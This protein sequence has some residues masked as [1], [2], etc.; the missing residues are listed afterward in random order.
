MGSIGIVAM[1]RA[2]GRPNRLKTGKAADSWT[3]FC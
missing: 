2:V 1:D 3:K